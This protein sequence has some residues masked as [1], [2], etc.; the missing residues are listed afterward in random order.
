MS[1]TA[2]EK[3]FEINRGG[4]KAPRRTGMTK[5][6]D[7]SAKLAA[8]VE[9]FLKRGGQVKDCATGKP[10]TPWKPAFNEVPEEAMY[11]SQN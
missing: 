8:D 5:K 3:P 6:R 4:E 11:V 1:R 9:A 10:G 2:N 7:Q